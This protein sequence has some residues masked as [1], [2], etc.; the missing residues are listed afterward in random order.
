MWGQT[1]ELKTSGMHLLVSDVCLNC[2]DVLRCRSQTARIEP[3]ATQLLREMNCCAGC[4]LHRPRQ[5]QYSTMQLQFGKAALW[6]DLHSLGLL[7]SIAACP[8]CGI[9]AFLCWTICQQQALLF[10]QAQ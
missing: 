1:A 6:S 8:S 9:P 7:C 3:S 10:L 2:Q 5:T 4:M